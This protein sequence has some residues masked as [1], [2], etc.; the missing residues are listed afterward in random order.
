MESETSEERSR[1]TDDTYAALVQAIFRKELGPGARLSVPALARKLE[2]SR[3]PVREAVIRLLRE[4][5]A[6]EQPRR[7]AVVAE[8]TQHDLRRIYEVREVLEGLAARL[9]AARMTQGNLRELREIHAMH[10]TA[11][12]AGDLEAHH[13]YDAKFHSCTRQ[14]SGNRDLVDMLDRLQAKVTMAMHTTTVTA[15]PAMALRDHRKILEALGKRDATA[16][17]T[18]ARHHISRLRGHLAG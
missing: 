16:A 11:V 15:G 9:A 1:I 10:E 8:I 2:V 14:I 7:G 12:L 6:V 18:A 17:E 5:L 4:G 3:T 13:E